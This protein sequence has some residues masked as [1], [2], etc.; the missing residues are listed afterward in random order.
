MS[1][2]GKEIAA[3]TLDD[4]RLVLFD[5]LLQRRMEVTRGKR[6]YSAYWSR[7]EKYIYFQDVGSV[8]QPIY[9]AR[10]SDRKIEL[11][12]G[13]SQ[14]SRADAM[15]FSLAGVAPDGSPLA[16]LMLNRGEIYAFDVDLP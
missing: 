6:L 5:P 2:D 8:E 12:A 13:L 14:L 4:T 15:A 11:L 1:P 7:D 10:I 3:F 16:S 9:R